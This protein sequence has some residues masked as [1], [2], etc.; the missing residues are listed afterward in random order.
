M[1][2]GKNAGFGIGLMDTAPDS[3]ENCPRC[4]ARALVTHSEP[5]SGGG[6]SVHEHVCRRCR[7]SW[8]SEP[9]S[10]LLC[11]LPQCDAHGQDAT[12]FNCRKSMINSALIG[13]FPEE[14]A[15]A[16][17]R[18]EAGLQSSVC[19]DPELLQIIRTLWNGFGQDLGAAV[20][21]LHKVNAELGGAP[22]VLLFGPEGGAAIISHLASQP[23]PV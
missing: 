4:G 1:A 23:L 17:L 2:R 16:L 18:V 14:G 9:A 20:K 5:M 19:T 10:W 12:G 3:F 21:W 13:D 15:A 7:H 11:P 6:R 22:A 8:R